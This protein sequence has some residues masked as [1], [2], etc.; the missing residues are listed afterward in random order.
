MLTNALPQLYS[1]VVKHVK[2]DIINWLLL[3]QMYCLEQHHHKN[4]TEALYTVTLLLL[5]LLLLSA[6]I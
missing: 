3:L 5:L 2:Y 1:W 4:A 6:F